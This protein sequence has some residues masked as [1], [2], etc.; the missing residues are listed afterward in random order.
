M[1]REKNGREPIECM[2]GHLRKAQDVSVRETGDIS[3]GWKEKETVMLQ[4][5]RQKESEQMGGKSQ[6]S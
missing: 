1:R 6:R 3:R 4:K 2:V 5:Q